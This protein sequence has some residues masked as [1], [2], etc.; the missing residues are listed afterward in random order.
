M[1]VLGVLFSYL[2]FPMPS[3]QAEVELASTPTDLHDLPSV[4]S[5]TDL[6]M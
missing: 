6:N 4:R 3:D 1:H 5:K 2:G